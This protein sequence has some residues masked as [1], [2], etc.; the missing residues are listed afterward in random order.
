MIGLYATWAVVC[1]VQWNDSGMDLDDKSMLHVGR[2]PLYPQMDFELL[3]LIQFS[4]N[5]HCSLDYVTFIICLHEA[6]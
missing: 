3:S 1:I 5:K 6:I 4:R 2:N